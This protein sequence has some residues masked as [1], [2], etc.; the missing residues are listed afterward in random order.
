[1]LSKSLAHSE[2]TDAIIGAFY[3]VANDLGHGFSEDV[4]SRAMQ[5]LL[6]ERGHRVRREVE[7]EVAYHGCLIGKFFI[8]L[9]IDETVLVEIKATAEL[10]SWQEAQL[11]NYLKAAGGGVGLLL[12]FGRTPQVRRRVMGNPLASLPHLRTS[13]S[14]EEQPERRLPPIGVQRRND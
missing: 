12:N 2:L 11:L 1:M 4:L 13:G 9:V 7:C 6:V 10:Q 8:D 5:I 3:D 14:R